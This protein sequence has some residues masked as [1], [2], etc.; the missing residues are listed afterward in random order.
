MGERSANTGPRYYGSV[1]ALCPDDVLTF[2]CLICGHQASMEARALT[3]RVSSKL[4][5]EDI[6][7]RLR[8]TRCRARGQVQLIRIDLADE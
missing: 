1:D 8:C 6:D 4:K 7:A 5:V 2:A 3:E